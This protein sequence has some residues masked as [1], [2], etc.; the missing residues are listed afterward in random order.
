VIIKGKRK[1]QRLS[2]K[3][4]E[5]RTL[6]VTYTELL[7]LYKELEREL[8]K[9]LKFAS[10]GHGHAIYQTLIVDEEFEETLKNHLT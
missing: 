10:Y 9:A 1:Y 5:L 2:V 3:N 6:V 7:E 8:K 4:G